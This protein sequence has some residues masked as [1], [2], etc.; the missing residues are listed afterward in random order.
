MVS[1]ELIGSMVYIGAT[2]AIGAF[3][4]LMERRG[5]CHGRGR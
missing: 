5:T 2:M 4:R 1:P 3:R